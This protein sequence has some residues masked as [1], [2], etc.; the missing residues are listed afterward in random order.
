MAVDAPAAHRS[1][2]D[3]QTVGQ[4]LA[5]DSNSCETFGHDREPITLLHAQFRI[6]TSDPAYSDS[7]AE[8]TMTRHRPSARSR[9]RSQGSGMSSSIARVTARMPAPYH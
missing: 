4:Q 2:L 5:L 6:T 3:A 1:A 8:P 9:C 7:T